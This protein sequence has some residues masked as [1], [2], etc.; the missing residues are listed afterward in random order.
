MLLKLEYGY[1]LM[2]ALGTEIFLLPN[3]LNILI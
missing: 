3:L 1:I 2:Q